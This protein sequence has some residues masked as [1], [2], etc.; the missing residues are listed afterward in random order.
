MKISEYFIDREHKNN[1]HF[2]AKIIFWFEFYM[3]YNNEEKTLDF[4]EKGSNYK[5]E[6][7]ISWK[8][9]LDWCEMREIRMCLCVV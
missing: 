5:A 2:V 9:A 8:D 4:E 1:F 3:N 6:W 7:L